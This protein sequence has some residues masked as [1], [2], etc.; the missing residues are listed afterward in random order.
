MAT[1]I[2]FVKR[3]AMFMSESVRLQEPDM[4]F[5][6]AHSHFQTMFPE[7]LKAGLHSRGMKQFGSL[8]QV[9]DSWEKAQHFTVGQGKNVWH[10]H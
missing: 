2:D 9:C 8:Q 10:L 4:S 6:A 1:D 3:L 5:D 7:V